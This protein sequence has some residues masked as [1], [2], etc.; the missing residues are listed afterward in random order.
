MN[1]AEAMKKLEMIGQESILSAWS[2]LTAQE[3]NA[4]LEQ[5]AALDVATF[6]Q[7]QKL[8]FE[9]LKKD[10]TRIEVFSSYAHN[11]NKKD[12]EAGRK[13][14][15]EGKLGCL[16]IA[17]GQG[18][19]LRIEGPKGIFPVS[20]IKQKSLF[21]LVSE[22]VLAAGKQAGK[23]LPL[24]IMTSPLNDEATKAFFLEN[25]Y[26]GLNPE[27]VTFF[28]QGMLPFLDK[29][30]NL[31]N[32]S[33]S[34]IALGPDGN[35]SSLSR[36]FEDGVWEKWHRQGVEYVNFILIDNALAD[37]FDSELLGF[38]TRQLA[39][40]TVKCTPRRNAVEKVGLLVKQGND[41]RVVE[42]TEMPDNE[43][44]ATNADG[45]LKHTCANLSLFCMNMNFVKLCHERQMPLHSAFK[46]MNGKDNLMV[47]KSEKFIFDILP[48][49]NKVVALLYPRDATFAPLKNFS[50][51]DSLA[52]V[53]QA[54]Q[55]QA[56]EVF[57]AITGTTPPTD[58][59]FE[60]S[61]E[62]LYPTP[63]L[64]AK[65]KGAP[66]PAGASYIEP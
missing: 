34:K 3:Q 56:R 19:R 6:R 35:G 61:A 64:L 43:R 39:D 58:A 54:L 2:T 52:G 25:K 65:W 17:G 38:H 18:T 41:V 29:E 42:Y 16:L 49:A 21:Q 53:Q 23:E 4:L 33:P 55:K 48:F 14:I 13:L 20:I 46:A 59:S 31:V 36:F 44:Q 27:Q 57:A 5:I 32:E 7:Q 63:A 40:I 22:K 28:M 50:G 26:F 10:D 11:G 60:L 15:A 62:F 12:H 51:D 66:F 30:G 1:Y 47:W 37:P 9:P 24:A 8:V 45:T